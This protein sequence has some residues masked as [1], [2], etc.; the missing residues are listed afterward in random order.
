MPELLR[1]DFS[2][3]GLAESASRKKSHLF[4]PLSS[5]DQRLVMNKTTEKYEECKDGGE[6]R[7]LVAYF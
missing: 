6:Q 2:P 4:I 7:S 1:F 5:A 3:S